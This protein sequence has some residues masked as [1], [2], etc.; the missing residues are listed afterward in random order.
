MKQTVS[1]S[2]RN[3]E[4]AGRRVVVEHI[5]GTAIT[6]DARDPTAADADFDRF[7]GMMRDVDQR[8]STFRSDSEVSRL[9][10][11]SLAREEVST[12][13]REVLDL[14]EMV[15]LQSDGAFDIQK[16][17]PGGVVDPTGLVKGWAI[18]RGAD[19]LSTLGWRNFC[20]NAG[21]DVIARGEPEPGRPWR[22][23]IRHPIEARKMATVVLLRDMTIATSGTYERGQHILDPATGVPPWALLSISVIGPELTLADA[24]ATAAFVKG[25]D[26]PAW[27]AALDG[28]EAF[29]ATVDGRA[30]WTDGC[31]RLLAP[32]VSKSDG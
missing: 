20:I 16:H 2:S 19:L 3:H 18:D 5:M 6:V 13:L 15:R 17:T 8:F 23:G 30:I 28:Y 4:F 29:A 12:Q 10:D 14:C 21:G 25:R 31:D 27:V 11:G 26:G 1:R 9:A 32:D 7:F 24:Y 22:I